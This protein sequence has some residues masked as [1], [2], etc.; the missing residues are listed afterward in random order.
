MFRE[1]LCSRLHSISGIKLTTRTG[2]CEI[3]AQGLAPFGGSFA[4]LLPRFTNEDVNEG[5]N[6]AEKDQKAPEREAEK[7]QKA[8]ERE[9]EK[10]QKAPEREARQPSVKKINSVKKSAVKK[11]VGDSNEEEHSDLR[12]VFDDFD[13]NRDGEVN[14]EE[15]QQ[16]AW[17]LGVVLTSLTLTLT[18]TLIVMA[19][20]CGPHFG[21]GS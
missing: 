13:L 9:A 5:V 3:R 20:R 8:P 7:D 16:M 14:S 17:R 10:D 12:K 4:Q 2:Q 1:V 6:E 15:L 19:V 11:R 18:L 21:G